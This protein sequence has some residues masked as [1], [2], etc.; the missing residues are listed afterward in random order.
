ML[1]DGGLLRLAT[2]WEE[3]ALQMRDVMSDAADFAP[4]FEGE[5]APRFAGRTMTAFERKGLAKGRDIRDLAY[6]RV[7]RR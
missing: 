6:E 1:R 2:D 3:Y 5:W 4:A 7:P